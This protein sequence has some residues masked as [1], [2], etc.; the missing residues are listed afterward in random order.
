MEVRMAKVKRQERK[1][2]EPQLRVEVKGIRNNGKADRHDV[3]LCFSSV[4]G[5]TRLYTETGHA[6]IT[7]TPD[8]ANALALRLG[9]TY[10]WLTDKYPS[11]QRLF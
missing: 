4:K 2:P 7:L 6:M 5:N 3:V 1:F 9:Q 10:Q 8:E 11:Y